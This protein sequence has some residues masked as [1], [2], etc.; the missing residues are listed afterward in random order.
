MIKQISD[1]RQS[2]N[3]DFTLVQGYETSNNMPGFHN[4]VY[5]KWFTPR[6]QSDCLV[7][8]WNLTKV[9]TR[10]SFLRQHEPKYNVDHKPH[11]T[12]DAMK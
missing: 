4:Q 12:H 11:P 10:L 1:S 9:R 2:G 6:C 3:D 8:Y 5:Q 7:R